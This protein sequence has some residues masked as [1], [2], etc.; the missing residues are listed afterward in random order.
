LVCFELL[1]ATVVVG[2]WLNGIPNE[3]LEE[4]S[5][6]R[7]LCNVILQGYRAKEIFV[8]ENALLISLGKILPR[9]FITIAAKKLRAF[10]SSRNVSKEKT[11]T[12][13][14]SPYTD[15]RK[16]EIIKMQIR[17]AASNQD[18]TTKAAVDWSV[19]DTLKW[20]RDKNLGQYCLLF[21]END[22]D[23]KTLLDLGECD[24]KDLGIRSFGHR[25]TLV[26]LLNEVRNFKPTVKETLDKGLESD[27]SVEITIGE[28]EKSVEILEPGA[29][30]KDENTKPFG[31]DDSSSIL[32]IPLYQS[33][34]VRGLSQSILKND[35]VLSDIEN[36]VF[37]AYSVQTFHVSPKGILINIL[38]PL[39][40]SKRK[41]LNTRLVH[42]LKRE[43]LGDQL[44]GE[45]TIDFWENG[46]LIPKT[47]PKENIATPIRISY[48]G[49]FWDKLT[50]NCDTED[51]FDDEERKL[52]A[53]GAREV[54]ATV[55]NVD[56]KKIKKDDPGIKHLRGF[57]K[58]ELE[59]AF[60][61]CMPQVKYEI[62]GKAI[63]DQP[64][65]AGSS[66]SSPRGCYVG[67][68]IEC[69]PQ[70]ILDD[71]HCIYGIQKLVFKDVEVDRM[72]VLDDEPVLKLE[73]KKWI[74]PEKVPSI[75][76]NLRTFLKGSQVKEETIN[77]VKLSCLEWEDVAPTSQ[78]TKPLG[79]QNEH[80]KEISISSPKLNRTTT[81]VVIKGI[82]ES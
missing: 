45:V 73:F 81:T 32:K 67:M 68:Q 82:P 64:G 15:K 80:N 72:I 65:T 79:H 42:F 24:L 30:A 75:A 57:R 4:D 20:L 5:V 13:T 31:R 52:N 6:I 2:L 37:A 74:A 54:L 66:F 17:V 47:S 26:R 38:S 10:L 78:N 33:L 71:D 44:E 11:D 39:T 50:K 51:L 40:E 22:L 12:I 34:L 23:G 28:S 48:W 41:D 61:N 9:T 14:L 53:R 63:H 59:A 77:N 58:A 70:F 25:K 18:W 49:E 7:E 21:K 56:I 8:A 76:H 29:I 19:E 62:E 1:M 35:D 16:W 3:I 69:L 55:R 43:G 27:K 46:K 36:I 60:L